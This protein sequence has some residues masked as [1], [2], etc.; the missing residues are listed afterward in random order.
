MPSN[1]TVLQARHDALLAKDLLE[2]LFPTDRT[3]AHVRNIAEIHHPAFRAIRTDI[4]DGR[5]TL[6]QAS[7]AVLKTYYNLLDLPCRQKT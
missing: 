4:N 7:R 5:L 1:R 6:S 2:A 3:P